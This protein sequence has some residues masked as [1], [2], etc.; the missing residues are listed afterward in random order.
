MRGA[1]Y[2]L[3]RVMPRLHLPTLYIFAYRAGLKS[4][5]LIALSKATRI[6][7]PASASPFIFDRP[8]SLPL[9]FAPHTSC[10]VQPC[11]GS[12]ASS[13]HPSPCLSA[14]L[15]ASFPWASRP[16][17]TRSTSRSSL[18]PRWTPCSQTPSAPRRYITLY[19]I[20]SPAA[21]AAA[22]VETAAALATQL[23]LRHLSQ[24]LRA[25]WSPLQHRTRPLHHQCCYPPQPCTICM[26]RA[27]RCA[28]RPSTPFRIFSSRV[29]PLPVRPALSLRGGHPHRI[30]PAQQS[31]SHRISP[32]RRC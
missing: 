29:T 20:S 26:M 32:L 18:R 2:H 6:D 22:E 5:I 4:T 23:R 27:Q 28:A 7:P 15:C 1:L 10:G 12:T 8:S 19:A 14:S 30:S 31:P 9:L 21:A 3:T 13:S 24:Q 25:T 17:S 11:T 16:R